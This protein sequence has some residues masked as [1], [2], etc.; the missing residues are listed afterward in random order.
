MSATS[1]VNFDLLADYNPLPEIAE[2]PAAAAGKKDKSPTGTKRL[3][4]AAG[5]ATRK[6]PA[7]KVAKP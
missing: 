6:P 4:A 1:N 7:A 2:K 5:K 3:K